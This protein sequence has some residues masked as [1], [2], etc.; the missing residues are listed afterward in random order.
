MSLF[1]DEIYSSGLDRTARFPVDR[2][3]RIAKKISEGNE[4]GLIELKKPRLAKREEIL[5]AHDAD[6]ADRFLTQQ[7]GEVKSAELDYDHGNRKLLS[8]RCDW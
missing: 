1:Y 8:A 2:Y 4:N 6:Y 5:L 7:L 3:S